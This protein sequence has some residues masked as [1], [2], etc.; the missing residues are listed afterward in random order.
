MNNSVIKTGIYPFFGI[1]NDTC[2]VTNNYGDP[3]I[4]N[5]CYVKLADKIYQFTEN[6][7]DGYRSHCEDNI[8]CNRVLNSYRFS[9][10]TTPL[11]VRAELVD[12]FTPTKSENDLVY[13]NF[14]GLLLRNP[15]NNRIVGGFGTDNIDDYYPGYV[16]RL[17]MDEIQKCPPASKMSEVL[18]G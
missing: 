1:F 15:I 7:E 17:D 10:S 13:D 16:A 2:K 6:P 4:A 8:E 3:D 12:K 14:K 18:Y 5:V 11:L 9:L